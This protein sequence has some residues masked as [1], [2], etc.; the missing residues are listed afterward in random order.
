MCDLRRKCFFVELARFDRSLDP[1]IR[2]HRPF[3]RSALACHPVFSLRNCHRGFQ[4]KDVTVLFLSGANRGSKAVV[5][6]EVALDRLHLPVLN[7]HEFNV[8]ERLI[9]L[10]ETVVHH[11]RCIATSKYLQQIKPLDVINLSVPTS[12]FEIAFTYVVVAVGACKSEVVR[13]QHV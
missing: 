5:L 3:H 1:K 11:E 10:R 13:E 7:P 12:R 8:P 6:T 4:E 2:N 9:F